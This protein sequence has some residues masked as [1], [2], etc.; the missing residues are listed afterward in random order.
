MD[1]VV[2]AR[3]RHHLRAAPGDRADIG[4]LEAVL[5]EAEIFRRVDL[6]DR[7]GDREIHDLGRFVEA[8]RMLGAFVDDA[9]I[10]TLALEDAGAVM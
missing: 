6:G 5:R 1:G 3:N 2:H 7:I 10:G 9:V 8:L 4:V